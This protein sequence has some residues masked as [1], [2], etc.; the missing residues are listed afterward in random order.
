MV[1]G[2]EEEQ[3]E[4]EGQKQEEEEEEEEEEEKEKEKPIFA[5]TRGV[6]WVRG[7]RYAS[8]S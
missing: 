4:Q 1:W 5:H 7:L 2:K 3:A 8:C 6:L